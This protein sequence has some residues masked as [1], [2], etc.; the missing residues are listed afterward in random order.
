MATDAE[1]SDTDERPTKRLRVGDKD[2]VQMDQQEIE[3]EEIVAGNAS[4]E[5]NYEDEES[6]EIETR[7]RERL[8]KWQARQVAKGFVDN[9]INRVLENYVM[10]PPFNDIYPRLITRTNDMED[11][12]VAMAIQNHGLVQLTAN[13]VPSADPPARRNNPVNEYWVREDSVI[14]QDRCMCPLSIGQ[15]KA[16]TLAG[17]AAS[18]DET[19]GSLKQDEENAC[20]VGDKGDENNQQQDFLER[21]VAEAIKKKGL[22]A[23]SVDYG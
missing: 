13:Y 19:Y 18:S 8:K 22:S 2:R 12:A 23:L 3:T 10:S 4:R 20:W 6:N 17:S 1:E 16:D 11:R 15:N 9:T 14:E 7:A 21:A 5:E